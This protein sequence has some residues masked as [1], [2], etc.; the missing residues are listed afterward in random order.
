M[1]Q[2]IPLYIFLQDKE[3]NFQIQKQAFKNLIIIFVFLTF[4][5]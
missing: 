1:Y 3:Q 2:V 5:N 4:V